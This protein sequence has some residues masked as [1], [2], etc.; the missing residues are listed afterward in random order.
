MS[1]NFYLYDINIIYV[2]RIAIMLTYWYSLLLLTIVGAALFVGTHF[3]K[4]Q[5]GAHLE[6]TEADTEFLTKAVE[7]SRYGMENNYGGPFGAVLVKDGRIVGQGFNRVTSTN[8]PT[9]HAEVTA[10]RDA[11]SNLGTYDLKGATL[12]TSCEPCPMCLSASYWAHVGKIYYA[13]TQKDASSIGFDDHFIY[14]E[15]KKDVDDRNLPMIHVPLEDALDVFRTW[16]EQP[17]K[18]RY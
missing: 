3:L 18:K 13:N 10:I 14:M 8:D 11:C 2:S 12:Y 15:L 17:D 1:I 7:L 5:Y 9:A 16:A 4:S 6:V